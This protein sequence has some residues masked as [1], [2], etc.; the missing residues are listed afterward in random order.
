MSGDWEQWWNYDWSLITARLMPHKN[1]I[2]FIERGQIDIAGATLAKGRID[3]YNWEETQKQSGT[4]ID[5]HC[6]NVS[7]QH[8]SK[9]PKF[10]KVFEKFYGKI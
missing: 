5:M 10:L 3:R 7:T 6:E 9:L 8:E 4:F 1:K 2:T